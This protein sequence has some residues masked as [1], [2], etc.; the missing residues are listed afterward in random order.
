MLKEST[1]IILK[2]ENAIHFNDQILCVPSL[3]NIHT[4]GKERV[5]NLIQK[6][7]FYREFESH[8]KKDK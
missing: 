4:S 6:S 2:S 3:E 7:M 1:L 8:L 5:S